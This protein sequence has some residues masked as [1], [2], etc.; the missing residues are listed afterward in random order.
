MTIGDDKPGPIKLEHI[1]VE[2][3]VTVGGMMK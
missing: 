1:S 3:A 2:R